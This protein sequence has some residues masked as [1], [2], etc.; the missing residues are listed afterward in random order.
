MRRFAAL[1]GL[2][3]CLVLQTTTALATV[4]YIEI[5]AGSGRTAP[6]ENACP[7]WVLEVNEDD[8]SY[9]GGNP[10][11]LGNSQWIGPVFSAGYYAPG[12]APLVFT[13]TLPLPPVTEPAPELPPGGKVG[14]PIDRGFIYI[15]D[16]DTPAAID[17]VIGGTIEF[18]AFQ[19]NVAVSAAARQVESLDRLIH[20]IAPIRVSSAADSGDGGHIYT[21]AQIDLEAAY[22]AP[23]LGPLDD[24]FPS[25]VASQ[26]TGDISDQPYWVA[27][28]TNGIARLDDAEVVGTRTTVTVWGYSCDDGDGPPGAD[29]CVTGGI[30]W[31]GDSRAAISNLLLRITTDG[32]GN[33]SAAEAFQV[34]E[35]DLSSVVDG[36]DSWT[37]TR[38]S[39]SGV[40]TEGPAAFDD[41]AVLPTSLPSITADVLLNDNPGKAP[42]TVTIEMQPER[43]SATVLDSSSA[44]NR[45]QYVREG[46]EETEEVIVY[47]VTDADGVSATAELHVL[48]TDPVAC[49]DDE[50]DGQRDTAATAAVTENDS[51]FDLPPVTIRIISTPDEGTVIV[52]PDLTIT[53]TPPADTGG[54]FDIGYRLT[55]GANRPVTCSLRVNI[56]ALP[57]AVDDTVGVSQD[58]ALAIDV[59]ENDLELDNTPLDIEIV[60]E[61]QRG[62]AVPDLS[63]PDRPKVLYTPSAGETGPDT[64]TYRITDVDNDVSNEATVAITIYGA[65]VNDLPACVNDEAEVDRG[66]TVTIA[67]LENDTGLNAEPVTVEIVDVFPT[68]VGSAVANPDDSVSYTAPTDSGGLVRITYRAREG[69]NSPVQCSA[70]VTV[71]DL[72]VA[73]DNGVDGLNFGKLVQLTLLGNDSGLT[74]RPLLL[75]ITDPADHGTLTVCDSEDDGCPGFNAGADPYVTYVYDQVGDY[76]AVETFRYKVIDADGDESNEATVTITPRN[77]I[78]AE[79]DP[80]G[81]TY[82]PSD[83]RTASGYPITVDVISNDGGV[84]R[85]PIKVTLEEAP[86]GGTAVVNSDNSITYSPSKDYTGVA[87]FNY[88]LT[89]A[90]GASDL[91]M[92]TVVVFPAPVTDTG[93]SALDWLALLALGTAVGMRLRRRSGR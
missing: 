47:R 27:P 45:I 66:A 67:V 49:A 4:R 60:Q 58:V 55:D 28:G 26:S 82:Q 68:D 73:T 64:F 12:T 90:E 52:N 84:L 41:R 31:N 79:D 1:A 65:P 77:V 10:L 5:T 42:V 87:Q 37:A 59:L 88:R 46:E 14:I 20:R 86:P 62:T 3:T 17:D 35:A 40:A 8:C 44:P 50:V 91:A 11:G 2:T 23:L 61:P 89:D 78:S 56:P 29:G 85:T 80:D 92:V 34:N 71:D 75:Q 16:R 43:G 30:N 69:L 21:V 70:F 74:D 81:F 19:R 72:P 13:N 22:P 15:D 57:K 24:E 76:P 25:E 38:A 83:F 48:V 54:I 63:A 51:G 32:D 33:I 18:G 6:A 9:D 39:F 93:G 53:F 7:A 36:N